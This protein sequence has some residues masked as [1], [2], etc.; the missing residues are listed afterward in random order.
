MKDDYKKILDLEAR[1]SGSERR[2]LDVVGLEI[3]RQ[4]LSYRVPEQ[5][6]IR[7]IKEVSRGI[8]SLEFGRTIRL[9]LEQGL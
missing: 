3:L 6:S 5:S 9:I 1:N 4:Q 2:N 7:E 8:P